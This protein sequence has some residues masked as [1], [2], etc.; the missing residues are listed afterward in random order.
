MTQTSSDPISIG[1]VAFIGGGNMARSLIGGL[2]ARGV[3][4]ASLRVAD[5]V[6][7]IREGLQRDFGVRVFATAE[8]A[9]DGAGIWLLA[10]KPQMMRQVCNGL[11]IGR[12]HV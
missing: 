12:A 2:V 9:T 7:T 3:D 8:E 11:K 10:V 4:A 1:Q 6:D 5:P